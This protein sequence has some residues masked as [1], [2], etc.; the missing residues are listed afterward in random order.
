MNGKEI[1]RVIEA[2]EQQTLTLKKLIDENNTEIKSL[3]VEIGRMNEQHLQ[4]KLEI[5]DLRGENVWL[6]RENL[7]QKDRLQRIERDLRAKNVVINGIE[8]QED[9]TELPEFICQIMTDKLEIEVKEEDMESIERMGRKG[10]YP[11]TIHIKFRNESI[12]NNILKNRKKLKG[13]KVYV[14]EDYTREIRE[15]RKILRQVLKKERQQGKDGY[16]TYNKLIIDNDVY[17]VNS[18]DQETMSILR[19]GT[20]RRINEGVNNGKRTWEDTKAEAALAHEIIDVHEISME[21]KRNRIG[22]GEQSSIKAFLN[23]GTIHKKAD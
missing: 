18:I 7:E 5:E 9:E 20:Q 12:R 14:D 4:T 10:Q 22:R 21:K 6:K 16:I 17:D 11:R 3:K 13:T 1:E 23:Q 2:I 8:E 15:E 19:V